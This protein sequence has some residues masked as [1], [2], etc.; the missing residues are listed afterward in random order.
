MRFVAV[1][2]IV[3]WIIQDNLKEFRK[4]TYEKEQFQLKKDF[5]NKNIDFLFLNN[6]KAGNMYYRMFSDLEFEND[7]IK[8][9][10][11]WGY[12]GQKSV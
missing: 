9:W 6:Q 7:F 3:P 5:Y 10:K 12:D 8:L 1:G 11:E 2:T 4:E